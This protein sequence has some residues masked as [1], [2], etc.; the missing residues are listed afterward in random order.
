MWQ[1]RAGQ[2][3]G[4]GGNAFGG[5]VWTWANSAARLAQSVSPLEVG[6]VGFQVD[7]ARVYRLASVSPSVWWQLPAE[8][9]G[10]W[11]ELV[12][13]A[14][15]VASQPSGLGSP[16]G[17]NASGGTATARN[18][19]ATT[20]GTAQARLGYPTSAVAGQVAAYKTAAFPLASFPS[21]ALLGT[22]YVHRWTSA[23]R[24][25][26]MRWFAGLTSTFTG[27]LTSFLNCLGVGREANAN[28]QFWHNDGAGAP[29]TIDLGAANP[30]VPAGDYLQEVELYL[31][32]GGAR[33]GICYRN[34]D[35]GTEVSAS[36][37]ANVVDPTNAML[38]LYAAN[39]T[40]AA[41]VSL[42]FVTSQ[43]A[44]IIR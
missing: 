7:I 22:R 28:M 2:S 17:G 33:A 12:Q 21:S 27:A 5:Y 8:D 35:L 20:K 36:V 14:G 15:A 42:D 30:G 6:A 44:P 10:E 19:T 1:K 3:A 4:A 16:V 29:S 24:S 37:A 38:V 40:D 9:T 26:N 32:L 11:H 13:V 18:I 34:L 41:V 43:W 23:S 31:P 25:T 39:V